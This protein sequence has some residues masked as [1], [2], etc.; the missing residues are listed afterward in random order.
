MNAEEEPL[1]CDLLAELAS[2][3]NLDTYLEEH[4]PAS[5]DLPTYLQQLL[6]EREM[7]RIEAIHAAQLDETYGYQIFQGTR[8]PSRDKVLQVAFALRCDLKETQHLLAY[9]DAGALYPKNRRDAILIYALTHG[10]DLSQTE[11]ELYRFGETTILD[12]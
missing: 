7:K 6:Q 12:S 10:L 5:S 4:D 8:R 3:P 1:T 9:A 11:T 2:V